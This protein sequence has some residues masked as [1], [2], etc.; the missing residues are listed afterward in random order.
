MTR[1]H[2]ETATKPFANDGFDMNY[3]CCAICGVRLL[4]NKPYTWFCNHCYK[5]WSE[6]IH[7]DEPWV[8][9][10]TKLERARRYR[11]RKMR[12][13]GVTIVYLGLEFDIDNEGR[14]VRR[15]NGGSK[16]NG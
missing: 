15:Y 9:Y 16:Q 13:M 5:D 3:N 11:M 10:L 7:E 12:E 8:V 14:L 1:K 2:Q 4:P 6:A